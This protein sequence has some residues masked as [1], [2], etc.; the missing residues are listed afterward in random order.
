MEDSSVVTILISSDVWPVVLRA[1]CP[2]TLRDL[3]TLPE[4]QFANVQQFTRFQLTSH[5][6]LGQPSFPSNR[7]LGSREWCTSNLVEVSL[8]KAYTVKKY[9]Y[10]HK[11]SVFWRKR[12]NDEA[13]THV[14]VHY[15]VDLRTYTEPR[16]RWN[17]E[18]SPQNVRG[19][20]D[21]FCSVLFL[22]A[23]LW[24]PVTRRISNGNQQACD[25]RAKRNMVPS[26]EITRTR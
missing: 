15:S 16:F 11:F 2:I 19:Y 7:S 20:T 18:N 17:A 4:M 1:W 5:V 24:Q 14:V 3:Q 25:W 8:H 23:N 9:P 21:S 10:N 13:R 22:R 6:P 12:R 26:S